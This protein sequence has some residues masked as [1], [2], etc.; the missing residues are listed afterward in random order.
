MHDDI[1]DLIEAVK[2]LQRD[3]SKLRNDYDNTFAQGRV[4]DREHGKGVRIALDEKGEHKSD[5][6]RM[7]ALSGRSQALP[8]K[9][10]QVLVIQPYGD[11]RQGVALG[12]GHTNEKKDPAKDGDNTVLMD[13]G[14]VRVEGLG[15]GTA[16]IT[17][18]KI[19]LSVGGVSVT[20]TGDGVAISGG[21]VTHDS[22][23]IGKDHKHGG[24]MKGAAQTDEPV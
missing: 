15:D 5:W 2:S 11:P 23:N 19:V 7:A 10:E 21:K 3:H 13:F 24:V 17:A 4:T 18:K 6:A 12:L 1:R 20:I 14:G 16:Q 22:K 8:A 9:D